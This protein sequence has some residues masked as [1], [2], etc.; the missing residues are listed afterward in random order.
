MG[1]VCGCVIYIGVFQGLYGCVHC[2]GVQSV[3]RVYCMYKILLW[4]VVI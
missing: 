2:V 3:Y 1:A 4:C